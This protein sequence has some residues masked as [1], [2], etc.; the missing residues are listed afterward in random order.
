MADR[1]RV[2]YRAW[3]LIILVGLLGISAINPANRSDFL[4]E[5]SL[6][7]AALAAIIA[8]ERARPISNSS[9]TLLFVFLCLHILG[10][11][12]TYSFVPYEAW[13]RT[14]F[15]RGINE[16]FGW[17]RNHYDRLVHLAFGLLVLQPLRELIVERFTPLRGWWS[18]GISIAFLAMF[19]KVYELMEWIF[20]ET[21]SPEAAET[22]NGQQ[23]DM[24]DG[25]KDMA[26]ALTGSMITGA[27]LAF[28][29]HQSR[30]AG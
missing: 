13:S 8:L 22:Y 16:A 29:D 7:A 26:M 5:H 11:H 18:I 19:S 1:S 25:Q 17:E 4:L 6:T 12:Y 15:G 3:L 21:M 20:A 10:A 2:S 9:A 24:F 14:V 23:G 27:L 28:K 30:S